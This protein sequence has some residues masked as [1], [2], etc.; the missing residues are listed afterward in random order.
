M[1][2]LSLSR[3]AFQEDCGNSCGIRAVVIQFEVRALEGRLV[4]GVR[5][6][7]Q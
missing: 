5:T 7:L 6:D 3:R 4:H 2:G 1:R